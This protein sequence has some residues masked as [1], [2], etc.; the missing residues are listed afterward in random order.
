MEWLEQLE[1]SLDN[2]AKIVQF[3]LETLSILSVVVGL[4]KTIQFAIALNRRRRHNRPFPF[5][6]IRLRFGIWLALALEFQLGSDIVATTIAPTLEQLGKLALI[7][8]I[9]TFLNYF[10]GKELQVEYELQKQQSKLA[11]ERKPIDE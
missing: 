9:R 7:A 3:G 5:N 8:G 11:V 6:Q 1:I 10:L 2:F 4:I